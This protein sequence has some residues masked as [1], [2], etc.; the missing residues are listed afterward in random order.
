LNNPKYKDFT[1]QKFDGTGLKNETVT[2]PSEEI[3]TLVLNYREIIELTCLNEHL[4]EYITGFLYSEGII[5]NHDEIKSIE[6]SEN[7]AIVFTKDQTKS[8]DY[9][10]KIKRI[11]TGCHGGLVKAD[12]NGFI[13]NPASNISIS[14]ELIFNCR[15]ILEDES[16]GYKLTHCIHTACLFDL[17]GLLLFK[18]EDIGRHNTVD[19]TVGYSLKQNLIQE[20]NIIFVTGR[21]SSEMVGKILRTGVAGIFSISSPT[22]DAISLCKKYN[23]ALIARIRSK[24]LLV[25][26]KPDYIQ[27]D[28]K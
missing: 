5:D 11:I 6:F 8:N 21:I 28:I 18:C 1:I 27:L 26:N 7:K 17:E 10:D 16:T 2:T 4:T 20:N 22:L 15:N 23:I 19:K 25:F 12:V 3:I 13:R 24:S 9:Q 14:N